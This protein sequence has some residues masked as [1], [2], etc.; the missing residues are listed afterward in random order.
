VRPVAEAVGVA[1]QSVSKWK[2]VPAH[3]V[4]MVEQLTDIKR[5]V[6]RPDLYPPP[7]G[8]R[9][10]LPRPLI[11]KGP[12]LRSRAAALARASESTRRCS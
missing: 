4:L 8:N 5:E 6:L 12:P 3:H 2:L 1:P 11:K 7:G 10:I 9:A